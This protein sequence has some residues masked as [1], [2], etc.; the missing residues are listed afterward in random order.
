MEWYDAFMEAVVAADD[1]FGILVFVG[2]WLAG[3]V[4]VETAEL[5][6]HVDYAPGADG[7]FVGA[8]APFFEACFMDAVAAA[9]EDDGVGRSEHVLTT[10]RTVA[11][12][13][14]FDA[15]VCLSDVDA[16]AYCTDGAVV[17]VFPQTLT[18]ATD[19]TVIAVIDR[20]FRITVP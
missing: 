8:S 1:G 20:F 13:A 10:N 12:C 5:T 3:D 17:E 11:F 18:E 4:A 14:L 7:T 6:F 15:A 2:H 16:D 9:H 19:A